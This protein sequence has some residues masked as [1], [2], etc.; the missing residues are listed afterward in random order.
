[1]AHAANSRCGSSR[2]RVLLTLVL[3]T[4][5][6]SGEAL[7]GESSLMG[8]AASKPAGG[9]REAPASA[10]MHAPLVL[11]LA[12]RDSDVRTFSATEFRS[13]SYAQSDSGEPAREGILGDNAAFEGTVWQRMAEYRSQDR[14]RLLTLWQTRGSTLSL[15]AGK[16]GGPSL[17]W[18]SPWMMRDGATKGLFDRLLSV[19]LRGISNGSRNPAVRTTPEPA[20]Q[21]PSAAGTP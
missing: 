17:Q 15:Q 5:V 11:S 18:S 6:R 16:R 2:E 20:K 13:R 21:L 4:L 9:A 12:Q 19:P 8:D 14:V 10:A 1:M 7:S 3:Y